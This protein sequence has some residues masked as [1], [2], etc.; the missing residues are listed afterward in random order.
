MPQC[1]NIATAILTLFE[2]QLIIEACEVQAT[3]IIREKNIT[4]FFFGDNT[5]IEI[6]HDGAISGRVH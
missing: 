2:P 4:T 1:N 5:F 3:L 6:T